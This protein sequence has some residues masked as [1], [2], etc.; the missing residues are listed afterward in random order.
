MRPNPA[1]SGGG[2]TDIITDDIGNAYFAD[3][4]GLAAVSVAVTN[5]G[6]NTWRANPVTGQPAD[7]RQWLAI[8]NG[9]TSSAND[10]TVFLVFNQ[11]AFGWQ[12]YS[13]PGST[14]PTDPVGGV[15]YQ[16][17]A[18][19]T[20]GSITTDG[21]CGRLL[22]DPVNKVLYL[23]CN[24]PDH[25][26]IWKASVA[27]DQRTGLVFT[28]V[29][30]PTSPGGSIG[31]GRLFSDV[32]TDSAGNLYA[33]WVDTANNNVYLSSSINQGTTWTT[34]VQVNGDPANSNVMPWAIRGAQE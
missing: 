31:L 22:F 25:E 34:P 9:L 7:D 1:A 14:G 33:V 10:N 12:I 15:I 19:T 30:A 20:T 2:D 8:D 27:P 5:D 6:G 17:A 28:E 32:A 21:R 18:A 16:N 29:N 3:L 24:R 4:E 11:Q 26:R 23:P 13:S